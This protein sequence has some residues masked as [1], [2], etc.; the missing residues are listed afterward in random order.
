MKCEYM[1]PTASFKDRGSTLAVS[2]ARTI[3]ERHGI[4]QVAEDS[5][6]NAGV[7]IAAYSARAGL[8]C[9]VYVPERVSPVKAQLVEGF[10]ARLVRVAGSRADVS[11]AAGQEHPARL[12]LGHVYDPFFV[13]GIETLAFEVVEDL[14]WA[15]PAVVVC[16]ISA[17]TLLLGLLY[18]FERMM[19]SSVIDRAPKL[20]AVQT[21]RIS[22]IYSAFHGKAY[23]PPSSVDTV[24]DALV[25]TNPP[26]LKEIIEVLRRNAGIVEVVSE[27]ETLA[28]YVELA[29]RGFF[30]EPSSAVAYAGFQK[31]RRIQ[32][33]SDTVAVVV[34]T[35]AGLKTQRP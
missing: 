7:S 17:G 28:A 8:E 13:A 12:Y 18:G 23:T 1:L 5:S 19:S 16:P 27:E 10:G 33:R 21:E 32:A 35:G 6:G 3:C 30:V 25:S 14:G 31:F 34:L 4:K 11:R 24:A 26:R 22:P 2:N 20:I 15:S 29:S 9:V